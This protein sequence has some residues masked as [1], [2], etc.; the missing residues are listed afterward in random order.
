M[1]WVHDWDQFII[2]ANAGNIIVPAGIAIQLWKVPTTWVGQS[3]VVLRRLILLWVFGLQCNNGNWISHLFTQPNPGISS[4]YTTRSIMWFRRYTAME[5]GNEWEYGGGRQL[6]SVWFKLNRTDDEKWDQVSSQSMLWQ[7][8]CWDL[9]G[10]TK[11]SHLIKL[12]WTDP[13][14]L[15]Y[16]HNR[17]FSCR[18]TVLPSLLLQDRIEEVYYEFLCHSK[19]PKSW[20]RI[21]EEEAIF[22]TWR[23]KRQNIADKSR[24]KYLAVCFCKFNL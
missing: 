14:E 11:G 7:R 6:T 22:Q 4:L 8:D 12:E 5:E 9:A 15:F 2:W 24:T 21:F 13:N 20:S 16:H 3:T 17:T 10:S 19:V 18:P 1:D 23:K